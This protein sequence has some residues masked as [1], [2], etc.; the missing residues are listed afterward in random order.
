MPANCVTNPVNHT[1]QPATSLAVRQTSFTVSHNGFYWCNHDKLQDSL[2]EFLT[3]IILR[4]I[5]NTTRNELKRS[6]NC[7]ILPLFPTMT[8]PRRVQHQHQ[9]SNVELATSVKQNKRQ[10]SNNFRIPTLAHTLTV[11]LAYQHYCYSGRVVTVVRWCR[12][13]PCD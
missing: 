12:F 1:F 6:H 4:T 10:I 9:P 8:M 7:C 13:A 2:L 5:R 11:I 3:F